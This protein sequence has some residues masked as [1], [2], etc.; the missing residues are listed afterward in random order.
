M[1][2]ITYSAFNKFSLV[3]DTGRRSRCWH[4]GCLACIV[5]ISSDSP[6]K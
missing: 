1:G 3:S 6:S 4:S 2:Y 5:F